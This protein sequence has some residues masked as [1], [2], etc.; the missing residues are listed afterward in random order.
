MMLY[1]NLLSSTIIGDL[2]LSNRVIMAPLTRMR[3]GPGN[4]PTKLNA[5]YYGQRASAGLII[6]EATQISQQGQGYLDTPGIYTDEQEAG[7][8]HVVE[9]VH[10]RSGL[11]ALQ[12]WHVGRISHSKLQPN[13]ALPV[14]PSAIPAPAATARIPHE[15]GFLRVLCDGPRA[16][17][18]EEILGIVNDYRNSAIRAK[19]A[20]FDA[21]EVHAAN[22][23]L[24]NQFLSTNTNQRTDSYGGCLENRARIVLDVVDAVVSVFGAG[25]VGVRLSPNGIFNDIEDTDAEEMTSYLARGFSER[26]LAYLHIAEPDWAGGA[27]LSDEFRKSIR[28]NFKGALIFCSNY[29]AAKAEKIISSN[30]AD[31]VAFGRAFL[32]NPDLPERFRVSSPLNEA[33]SKTFYCGAEIGYTDYPALTKDKGNSELEHKNS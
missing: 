27:P 14:A 2:K 4:A 7:W 16:L 30:I 12:L 3:A 23:Y 26:G 19:R 10:S 11:I 25:R 1:P 9:R 29:T 6:T 20:G 22:G 28:D 17:E 15:D 18:L 33:D 31:A 13:N 32:A 8:K 24:L 21:I 5:E